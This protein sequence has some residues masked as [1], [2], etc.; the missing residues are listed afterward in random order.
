[1]S[2]MDS[3]FSQ[4]ASLIIGVHRGVKRSLPLEVPKTMRPQTQLELYPHTCLVLHALVTLEK[5]DVHPNPEFWNH[6][7]GCV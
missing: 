2:L 7:Q 3:V 5:D 6:S 1:M 4:T